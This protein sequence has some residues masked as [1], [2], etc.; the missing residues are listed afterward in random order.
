MEKFV[1]LIKSGKSVILDTDIGPD[2]DDV[3]SL[4]ILYH[5]AK[6]AG[7]PVLATVNCTSNP[8]G[9]GTL[10]VINRY[11][12][13]TD[14]RI[15]QYEKDGFLDG[16]ETLKFNRAL[17]EKFGGSINA[18]SSLETYRE[19]LESAKDGG[20]I[21][22][23]IGQFN[24]AAGALKAFPELFNKKISHIVS[25][26]AAFPEGREYNVFCDAEAAKCVFHNSSGEIICTGFEVGET[27]MTG[28]AGETDVENDPIKLAY[29]LY[30]GPSIIRNSWDLTAVH[31]ACTADEHFYK[32]SEPGRME[33]LPDGRNRF[34]ADEPGNCRYLIKNT[35]DEEL[36]AYLNKI[37]AEE[38]K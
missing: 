23:T 8:Y 7:I 22:I 21:L 25:M 33:I 24:T 32:I 27:V 35:S 17:T 20:V 9:N 36:A 13:Y 16:E 6:E 1:A 18:A 19:C 31:F 12:G 38:S 26:A 4:V 15:A 14:V 2:C 10:D 28:F 5:F 11:F 29:L 34:H 37:L 3:G 30:N